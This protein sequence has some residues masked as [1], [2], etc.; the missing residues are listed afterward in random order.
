MLPLWVHTPRFKTLSTNAEC[1]HESHV[2]RNPGE[3]Q[4]LL[5]PP[6]LPLMKPHWTQKH[7]RPLNPI[8]HLLLPILHILKR[9][10]QHHRL[11]LRKQPTLPRSS[12]LTLRL[13]PRVSVPSRPRL[14]ASSPWRKHPRNLRL[15]HHCL[16]AGKTPFS[17]AL[18]KR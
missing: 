5:R 12:L 13:N 1:S 18:S 16:N 9:P 3:R 8:H 10:K 4:R 17:L 6:L 2:D 11:A 14:Q 15:L 7:R